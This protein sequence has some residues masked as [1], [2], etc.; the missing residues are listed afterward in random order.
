[1]SIDKRVILCNIIF[2]LRSCLLKMQASLLH[3]YYSIRE[4]FIVQKQYCINIYWPN[5]LTPHFYI[6]KI[7][8][9]CQNLP[10]IDSNIVC[11][12][13]SWTV[14]AL[15]IAIEFVII[16]PWPLL[17]KSMLSDFDMF[18]GFISGKFSIHMFSRVSWVNKTRKTWYEMRRMS[19]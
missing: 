3:F 8:K 2:H 10:S 7:W 5:F 17:L 14:K 9:L 6:S 1:V 16:Q 19:V 12:L 13:H 11:G 18:S 15:K 4:R